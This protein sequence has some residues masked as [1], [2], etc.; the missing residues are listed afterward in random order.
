MPDP[1]Q[2]VHLGIGSKNVQVQ[3]LLYQRKGVLVAPD[4]ADGY[5]QH[6]DAPWSADSGKVQ[7][8]VY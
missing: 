3:G 1:C 4:Q 8:P 7:G 5:L 2:G 6:G